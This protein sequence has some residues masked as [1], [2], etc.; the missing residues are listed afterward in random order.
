MEAAEQEML[1]EKF[2]PKNTVS[3]TNWAVSTFE[4]WR[5]SRNSRA[6]TSESELVP[7]NCLQSC[8]RVL[9]KK[10]LSIFVAET[11]KQDGDPYSPGSLYLLMSGILRHMHSLNPACPNILNTEDHQFSRFHHT[12]DNVLRML[13]SDSVGVPKPAEVFTKEDEETLWM[14]GILSVDNPKGL[15]RAVFFS[16]WQIFLLARR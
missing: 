5:K 11:R 7:A 13:R 2:V 16:Q 3:S 6:G 10:W 14:K 8:D 12:L 4:S 9:L 15:H 1:S